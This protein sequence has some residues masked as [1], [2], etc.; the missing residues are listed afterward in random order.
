MSGD[1]KGDITSDRWYLFINL[2]SYVLPIALIVLIPWYLFYRPIDVTRGPWQVLDPGGAVENPLKFEV[3]LE[4]EGAVVEA[5]DLIQISRWGGSIDDKKIEQRDDDWWIWVGFRTEE[6]TPFYGM[7]PR[8]VR[9]LVGQKE[10][11]GV[12]FLESSRG[13]DSAAGTVYINP[14]GSFK[15]YRSSKG[16]KI[17]IPFRSESRYTIVHIKKVFKGQLKYRTTHLY[18]DTWIHYCVNWFNCEYIN[19]SREGWVDEARYDGVSADG[20]KATFQYGPVATP[21]KEWKSPGSVRVADKWRSSEWD[22][23]PVGVQVK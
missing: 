2:M 22:K 19:D 18:D 1:N 7:N 20:K 3:V 8:M 23:L 12:R 15:H 4:G 11:G 17:Y 16:S 21:G 10:G 6:E 13:D 14:F 5:G 9:A